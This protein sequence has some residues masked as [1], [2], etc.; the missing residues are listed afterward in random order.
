[1]GETLKSEEYR[2]TKQELEGWPINIMSYRVGDTFY[3][4]ID[5]VSPGARFARAEGPTREA[6]ESAALEKAAKYLKQ[7]RR[8]PTS[9]E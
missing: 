8:R 6:A 5:N 4:A 9:S 3:C 2:E 1:M 7:T